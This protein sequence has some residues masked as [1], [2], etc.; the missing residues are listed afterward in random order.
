VDADIV[1]PRP[2]QPPPAYPAVLEHVRERGHQARGR[3]ETCQLT[4]PG[5]VAP[6]ELVNPGVAGPGP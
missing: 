5:A 4:D 3:S 6:D 2:D 1:T